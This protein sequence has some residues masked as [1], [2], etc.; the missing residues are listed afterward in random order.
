MQKGNG[1]DTSGPGMAAS[2]LVGC[3]RV[4]ELALIVGAAR[5]GTTLLRLIL[6]AHPEVG[7][8]AEAGLPNLMSHMATVWMTVDA[9]VIGEPRG[10]D[11]GAPPP[12]RVGDTPQ[13]DN[14]A[15]NADRSVDPIADLPVEA[16]DW[17]RRAVGKPMLRYAARGH[18]RIY[19][20]KSLDSVHHL[21]L[22]AGLFPT[23]R[24]VLVFRHV[25]DTV[26]SGIEASPWGFQAYGYAPY[27]Q[28]SPSNSVAALASYWLAHVTAA[29]DWEAAHPDSCHRVRY[30]DLVFRPEETAGVILRFLGARE[31]LSVLE[32]AF[33][34]EPANGP[35]DYK[36][37]HTSEVHA[38]S[39][40]RGKRVPVAMLPPPLLELL[41]EKLQALG[42]DALTPAWNAEERPVD[43]GGG[44][45]WPQRLSDWMA[46][47]RVSPD[48]ASGLGSF[49]LV[50]EDHRALRWVVDPECGAVTQGDGEV[51]SVVTG[52][53]EDLALMLT[54]EENLGVLLRA[55]RIRHLAASEDAPPRG[56][57][58][59]VVKVV[60][61]LRQGRGVDGGRAMAAGGASTA[62]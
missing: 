54:G 30:E 37:L 32:R 40:G 58:E 23:V 27:V 56:R 4:P 16:R 44:G 39:V 43:L 46:E 36:V 13:G 62:G 41:N 47:V 33:R 45:V 22:V 8:P 7:C 17:I 6:D 34:R 31:D 38:A 12:E 25:M 19:V 3:A 18:K 29:L 42:Y 59:G 14:D 48:E 11:P 2:D 53:A 24:C 50:A 51:E 1:R 55:G 9:D 61:C 26:A 52:T 5:S 28:A 57:A 15:P 35:G 20:D 49:A 21:R 10:T 60:D